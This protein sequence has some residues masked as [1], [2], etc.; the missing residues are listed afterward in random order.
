MANTKPSTDAQDIACIK[1]DPETGQALI[2]CAPAFYTDNPPEVIR[3]ALASALDHL[4]EHFED[5]T[6]RVCLRA[7]VAKIAGLTEPTQA[8]SVQSQRVYEMVLDAAAS[9]VPTISV[10]ST[11]PLMLYL[12]TTK[13]AVVR[14]HLVSELRE[15][16]LRFSEDSVP[17]PDLSTMQLPRSSPHEGFVVI[18]VHMTPDEPPTPTTRH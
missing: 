16:G 2:G 10:Y 15:M 14:D 12:F 9:E 6:L 5:A 18:E 3:V 8:A 1:L 4:R 7:A 11:V 13:G 17:A